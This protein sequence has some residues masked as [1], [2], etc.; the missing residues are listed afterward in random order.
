MEA[1]AGDVLASILL[2]DGGH[3]RHGGAPSLPKAYTDAIDGTVIGPSAGSCGTAAYRG[4]QVIVE[5]IVSSRDVR[6][7][8]RIAGPARGYAR[9]G[10]VCIMLFLVASVPRSE[11]LQNR[12][13]RNDQRFTPDLTWISLLA[14]RRSMPSCIVALTFRHARTARMRWERV[15]FLKAPKT[16][17]GRDNLL[18][19][20]GVL[21]SVVVNPKNSAM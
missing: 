11:R 21:R 3:L 16:G 1:Q 5:D 18:V 2:V 8:K 20:A 13:T 9:P 7:T 15:V 17:A 6:E 12:Q 4:E 10:E 19:S 14:R